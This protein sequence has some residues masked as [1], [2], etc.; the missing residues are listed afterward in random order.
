MLVHL[1]L[2][3][4]LA[5]LEHGLLPG[6]QCGFW[7]GHGTVDMVFEA[8]QL[9]EKCQE[10]NQDLYSSFID[11]SKT[12]DTVCHEGLWK[13]MSK[14]GCPPTFIALAHSLHDGMFAWVLNDGQSSDAFPVTNGVKQGCVLAPSLFSILFTAA[15]LDAFSDNEDSI[16]LCFHTDG[17]LFNLKWL[18]AQTKVKITSVWPYLCWWLCSECKFRRL[19]QSMN[20]FSSVC[21]T[22]GLTIS[23]R[24][25]QV[26]CQPAPHTMQPNPGSQWREML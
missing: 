12:F 21:N 23:T 19:Q 18:Q 7:G 13:I 26:M 8:W 10:Q 25:M 5:H 6:N 15:L 2:N 17:N 4:L 14:S 3:H 24:K 11:L 16:K 9:Q 20:K 1:L 22:F